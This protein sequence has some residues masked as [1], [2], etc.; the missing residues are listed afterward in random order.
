MSS[1]FS[2]R[3][4]RVQPKPKV[5]ESPKPPRDAPPPP[6]ID[7]NFLVDCIY[8]PGMFGHVVNQS[9]NHPTYTPGTTVV[10]DVL[11]SMGEPV[12]IETTIGIGGAN[13]T[14]VVT[15]NST[16]DPPTTTT[17]TTTG[18]DGVLPDSDSTFTWSAAFTSGVWSWNVN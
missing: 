16:S 4:T 14:C 3:S 13:A 8:S 18:W 9:F 6:T 15:F 1:R 2:R 5:C 10:N 17:A 12:H 7:L 11:D